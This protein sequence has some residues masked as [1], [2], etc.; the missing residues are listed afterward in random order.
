MRT[1]CVRADEVEM[2][3]GRAINANYHTFR[4]RENFVV[5]FI[6]K[7]MNVFPSRV[8]NCYSFCTQLITVEVYCADVENA[9]LP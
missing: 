3:K 4:T 1:Q 5:Q 6:R 9:I 2:K 7:S 8:Y